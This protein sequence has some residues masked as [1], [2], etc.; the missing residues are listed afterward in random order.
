MSYPLPTLGVLTQKSFKNKLDELHEKILD[1][2]DIINDLW[3]R[4]QWAERRVLGLTVEMAGKDAEIVALKAELA[5][6]GAGQQANLGGGGEDV[7]AK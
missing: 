1:K 2:D 5:A 6:V 7:S 4:A 3:T